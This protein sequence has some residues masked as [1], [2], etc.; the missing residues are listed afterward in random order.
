MSLSVQQSRKAL[1]VQIQDFPVW[2]WVSNVTLVMITVDRPNQ[3]KSLCI[4]TKGMLVGM[5]PRTISIARCDIRDY[6][7][8]DMVFLRLFADRIADV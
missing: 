7:I 6:L 8:V 1:S 5:A 3:L 4:G 2:Y